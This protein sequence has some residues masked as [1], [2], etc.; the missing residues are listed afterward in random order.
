[1]VNKL[2]TNYCNCASDSNAIKHPGAIAVANSRNEVKLRLTRRSGSAVVAGS[3]YGS[4][5]LFGAN[6]SL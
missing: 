6:I 3:S 4:I 1:M 2:T 5:A